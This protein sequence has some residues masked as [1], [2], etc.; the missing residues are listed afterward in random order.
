VI[1]IVAATE[2]KPVG[3]SMFNHAPLFGGRDVA[4]YHQAVAV[5]V[6]EPTIQP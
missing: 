2:H 5:V 1:A 3:T 6:A 4:H